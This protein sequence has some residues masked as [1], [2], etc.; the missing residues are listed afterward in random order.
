MSTKSKQVNALK[1]YKALRTGGVICDLV[2]EIRVPKHYF[3]NIFNQQRSLSAFS[4]SKVPVSYFTKYFVEITFS[5]FYEESIPVD[6]LKAS[7]SLAIEFRTGN[8]PEGYCYGWTRL[9]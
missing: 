6:P 7:A 4:S 2:N 5:S 9:R 8:T 1:I 3:V